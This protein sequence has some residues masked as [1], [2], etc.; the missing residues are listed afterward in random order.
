VVDVRNA[1]EVRAA[2]EA[3]AAGG[4]LDLL[5]N[6]AGI[7]VSGETPEIPLAH[8]EHIL[9]INVRG[10]IHGVAA[11][12]PIMVRQGYGHILAVPSVRPPSRLSD[13]AHTHCLSPRRP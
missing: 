11:G 4:R 7:G 8:W 13:N 3:A 9:D 12:Y 10:V 5:V 1:E 2:I 6:N